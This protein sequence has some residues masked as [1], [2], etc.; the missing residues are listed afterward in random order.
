MKGFRALRTLSSIS[1]KP[2]SLTACF[3]FYSAPDAASDDSENDAV[4]DSSHFA[5]PKGLASSDNPT[6]DDRY[7]HRVKKHIFQE[8]IQ[9]KQALQEQEKLKRD[10]ANALL[11]RT[12]L[13]VAITPNYDE[14]HDEIKEEDQKSLSVGIVGAPN[15]GKSALT[16]FMVGTKVSAVSRKIN[17]TT[18]EVL[19]VMTKGDTQICFFDTPGLMLTK[20]GYPHKD[21]KVRVESVWSA[22]ELYD[23]LIVIFDVHRHLT[24]LV[25]SQGLL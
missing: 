25:T 2:D 15:A 4:F 12:L 9:D 24:R 5:L 16:N 21:M 18:H 14:D 17:T 20:G 10:R 1:S 11:A 7:R 8:Q 23:V 19:G 3:R 13:D 22:V 6:W